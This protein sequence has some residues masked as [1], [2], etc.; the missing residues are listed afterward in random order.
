MGFRSDS[1]EASKL[2]PS[3]CSSQF[4]GVSFLKTTSRSQLTD[5]LS[6]LDSLKQC[7][8]L[9]RCLPINCALLSTSE[10]EVNFHSVGSEK[11]IDLCNAASQAGSSCAR[12]VAAAV[13]TAHVQ[14][15]KNDEWIFLKFGTQKFG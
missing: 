5:S 9:F 7:F 13:P 14:K 6:L 8:S 1:A 12:A 4:S 3:R 11:Q 15:F 2:I 10:E